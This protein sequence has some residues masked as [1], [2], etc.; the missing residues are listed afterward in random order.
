MRNF[1]FLPLNGCF[2]DFDM[3]VVSVCVYVCVCTASII[4][5]VI[6]GL[7]LDMRELGRSRRIS[8]NNIYPLNVKADKL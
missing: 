7:N 3:C 1:I 6:K 4:G 2:I 8:E 5:E